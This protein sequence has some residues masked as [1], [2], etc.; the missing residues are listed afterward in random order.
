M[1]CPCLVM[2]QHLTHRGCCCERHAKDGH[3]DVTLPF[4]SRH[5]VHEPDLRVKQAADFG[6]DL[7]TFSVM[8]GQLNTNPSPFWTM[9]LGRAGHETPVRG[10]LDDRSPRTFKG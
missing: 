2:S 6:F 7:V 1:R 9:G 8:R 4:V 5:D 10:S 3:A